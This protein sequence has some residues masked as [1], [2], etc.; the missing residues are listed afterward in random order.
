MMKKMIV[1]CAGEWAQKLLTIERYKEIEYFIESEP[2]DRKFTDF[3]GEAYAK[4]IYSPDV[5]DKEDPND[6]II[7]ISDNV[8]YAEAKSILE[9]KGLVENKHFF[10]G[11]KLDFTYYKRY[12]GDNSWQNF[13]E[14]D[15]VGVNQKSY[16]IRAK[17][18]N[19]LIPNDVASVMDVG[20]GNCELKQYLSS[21]IRYYGLD[22]LARNGVDFVCDINNDMIPDI[23][24]DLYYLA[25]LIYYADDPDRLISQFKNAKYILLDYGGTERYLRLDGVP[26]DPLVNARNNFISTDELFRI[27]RKNGFIFEDGMWDYQ[28]GKI[29][30]HFYLF[31]NINTV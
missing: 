4:P 2:G 13:E 21:D 11:W 7:I 25:G 29:G 20:C 28:N 30:W 3:F 24:V 16:G 1:Y 10:N 8:K 19:K 23:H 12:Y 26:D 27:L 6:I 17:I 9:S 31:K 14:T 15:S 18:M 5:L 22:F